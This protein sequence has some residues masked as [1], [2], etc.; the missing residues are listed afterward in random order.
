MQLGR[1]R[2]RADIGQNRPSRAISG[3]TTAIFPASLA[4]GVLV[5][6]SVGRQSSVCNPSIAV[7]HNL[8][9]EHHELTRRRKQ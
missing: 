9:D 4:A 3:F 7:L 2:R 8:R 5:R 6:V 1:H